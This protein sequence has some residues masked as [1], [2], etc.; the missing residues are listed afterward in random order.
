MEEAVKKPFIPRDKPKSWVV[1]IISVLIAVLVAGPI[2]IAGIKL[3]LSILESIGYLLF[4]G[5]WLVGI[6]SW[7]VFSGNTAKGK[8]K[9]MRAEKWADQKW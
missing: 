9:N 1:F 7:F 2:A 3:E 8:Y 5:S 6:V 4:I